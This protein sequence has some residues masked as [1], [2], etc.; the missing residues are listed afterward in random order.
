MSQPP[1]FVGIDVGGQTIKGGVV[2]DLGHALS[3]V[4]VP[5]EAAKGQEHGLGQMCE[6]VRRAVAT[7]GLRLDDI[8]AIGVA[9]PGTMDIPAGIILDPPNLRPWKNVPVRQH[10]ADTFGKPTAFQNDAN[11]AAFG[12]YWVGA[13][14]EAKSM[15]LFTLG[16]GIGCGIIIHDQVLEGQ[17]SHGAE[18]GHI[19]VEAT[20]GRMCGCG[21]PGHLEAYASA[22]AVVKRTREALEQPGLTSCL[23]E[24]LKVQGD[25]TARDVFDA[26]RDGD[27]LAQRIVE[28]TAYYLA[29]GAVCMMHTIDPDMVV[30]GGGM[31]AAGEEFLDRIRH[32]I[33][34]MAFPVPA[35]RTAVCYAKLGTDAGFIGAAA[36]AR[37]LYQR[38][39]AAK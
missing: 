28:E 30:F 20:N 33:R 14:R 26:A 1:Y 7:S 19:I 3:S 32:H 27:S 23:S 24:V 5:T 21:Q 10:I 11:A 39:A 6:A 29:V 35:E 37:Q 16:T 22:T 34:R 31:I 12:E 18:V 4:S 8:A 17:H 25:L 9:T 36:C 38:L 2:D 15:V 13:G